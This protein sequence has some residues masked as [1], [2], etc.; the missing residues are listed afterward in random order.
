MN[1]SVVLDREAKA[2]VD[3]HRAAAKKWVEK[4]D[5]LAETYSYDC[6]LS[7]A[8]LAATYLSLDLKRG[9]TTFEQFQ[10]G[11]A[12][13]VGGYTGWGTAWFNVPVEQL[14]GKNAGFSVEIVGIVGG[15]AHVQIFGDD[16]VG[17][18][19]TDGVGIGAGFGTGAGAFK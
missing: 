4:P 10:G 11:F 13:A 2:A 3:K 16:F 8:G 17:A 12:P 14:V 7:L 19:S 6:W 9:G 18:A 15:T 1:E 5:A